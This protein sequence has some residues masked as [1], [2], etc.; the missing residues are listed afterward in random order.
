MIPQGAKFKVDNRPI[1]S[2]AVVQ[3]HDML[4]E[5]TEELQSEESM[6]EASSLD[7][8]CEIPEEPQVPSQ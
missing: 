2:Q 8:I 5:V 4:G 3:L 1:T 7:E 6:E